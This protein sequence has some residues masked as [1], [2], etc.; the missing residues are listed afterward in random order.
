MFELWTQ[1]L[2]T[3]FDQTRFK[4]YFNMFM[5]NLHFKISI[6]CS[7]PMYFPNSNVNLKEKKQ[8]NITFYYGMDAEQE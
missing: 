2:N 4:I 1:N 7:N 3:T 6:N 5:I 8:S